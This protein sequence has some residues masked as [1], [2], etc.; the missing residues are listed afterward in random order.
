MAGV[1]R[2]KQD[3]EGKG[4]PST[5]AAQAKALSQGDNDACGG[6]PAVAHGV[7]EGAG[8]GLQGRSL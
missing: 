2:G 1:T 5:G 3:G 4:I 8:Q 6:P 7:W